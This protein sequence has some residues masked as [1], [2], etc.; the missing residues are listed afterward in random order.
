MPKDDRFRRDDT[1]E[2]ALYEQAETTD[3]T[4]SRFLEESH[5]RLKAGEHVYT[6]SDGKRLLHYAWVQRN[7]GPT[8]TEIG[9]QV[10]Y[11][12]HSVVFYDDYTLPVSRGLGLHTAS[13]RH[14]LAESSTMPE[15]EHIF[16]NVLAANAPSRRN[17][18][19]VGFLHY[20]TLTRTVRAARRRWTWNFDV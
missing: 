6:L 13:L 9:G 2:L 11:P 5:A 7:A 1:S 16:I 19:K 12:P 17:I 18:E 3:R 8:G 4:K 14:R 20:G 10:D 15:V